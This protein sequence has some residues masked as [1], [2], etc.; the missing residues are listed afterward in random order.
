[1]PG[2]DHHTAWGGDMSK[3][4]EEEG[5]YTTSG[6]HGATIDRISSPDETSRLLPINDSEDPGVDPLTRKDTWVGAK[7]YA[8]LPWYKRPSVCTAASL[9]ES[10]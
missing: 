5:V 4:A 7:E 9:A 2:A 6:P 8:H 1:M 3:G 10:T